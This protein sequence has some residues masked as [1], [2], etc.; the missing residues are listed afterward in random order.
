VTVDFAPAQLLLT[1]CF[2]GDGGGEQALL[3]HVSHSTV[4][5]EH[6]T[7]A[8][9]NDG[10]LTQ[11]LT[12][13]GVV[14]E[15]LGRARR[16]SP[17]PST[18]EIYQI[19]WQLARLLR[20]QR[21]AHVMCWTMQDLLAALVAK[22]LASFRLVWRSQGE[23]TIF[24]PDAPPDARMQRFV[25]DVAASVDAVIATSAWDAA[26]LHR[27]GVPADRIRVE[28][29][30]VPDEFFSAAPRSTIPPERFRL[31]LSGRL[32]SWKGQATLIRALAVLRDRLPS[33]DVWFAGDGDADYRASLE[34]EAAVLGVADRISFLG[35]QD[36]IPELLAQAHVAVH[37][38][39]REPFGLVIVEAM[40]SRLPVVAAAV[41]G[42]KEILREGT[43]LLVAP[44]D[45]DAYAAAISRLVGDWPAA[46]AMGQRGFED[47]RDRFR[48]AV[49]VPR[50]EREM[51]REHAA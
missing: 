41:E 16:D 29:L 9:L 51:F 40:A 20:R 22:R 4:R 2:A 42:P 35:H 38:S 26:A 3:R 33:V 19:G 44:G 27:W 32:V 43:G 23:K 34:R 11:R 47:A 12:R 50:V 15:R 25:R 18:L 10:P 1:N 49:N 39:E 37:C 46:V 17:F 8:L 31:L 30:G 6:I 14:C 7:V 13:C 24:S 5:A 45:A 36:R 21:I 28:Y 48:C